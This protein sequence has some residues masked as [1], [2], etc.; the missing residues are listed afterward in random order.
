M[1]LKG[2]GYTF[3]VAVPGPVASTLMAPMP[4]QEQVERFVS[5]PGEM[6]RYNSKLPIVIY[7]PEGCEVRYLICSAGEELKVN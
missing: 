2:W 6:I 7:T 4:R 3:Y 1:P 5:M